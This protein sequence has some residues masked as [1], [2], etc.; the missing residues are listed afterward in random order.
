MW[1]SPCSWERQILTCSVSVGKSEVLGVSLAV[2]RLEK[3][4]TLEPQ[5][6]KTSLIAL[7]AKTE[8]A[9]VHSVTELLE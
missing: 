9:Q 8:F 4:M 5:F 1:H 7:M 6:T 2:L 3:E